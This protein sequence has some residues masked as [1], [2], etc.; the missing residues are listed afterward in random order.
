MID[1][2]E[3]ALIDLRKQLSKCDRRLGQYRSALDA[4][5][6]PVEISSW[7]NET[8][9]ERARLEGESKAV[10]AAQRV[11]IADIR[12][13]IEEVGDLVRLASEADPD[14]KAELYTRLGLH[15]PEKQNVEA[16]IQPEPPH[17]R[18]VCVRGLSATDYTWPAAILIPVH[19]I[20][21]A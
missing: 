7:I 6:D 15:H 3:A 5:G 13:M 9:S 19:H 14:D 16:R 17:V 1:P 11:T 10:P 12:S 18:A 8:K 21:V 20:H 4:G 2:N